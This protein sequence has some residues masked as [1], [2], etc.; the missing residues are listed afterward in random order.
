M[1]STYIPI[2]IFVAVATGFALFTL[3]FSSLIHSEKYNKV[4]LEPYECGID[5]VTEAHDRFTVR[6][7]IVAM[8]F[9]QIFDDPKIPI[10]LKG[11]IGR[12]QLPF[13]AMAPLLVWVTEK[14][15]TVVVWVARRWAASRSISRSSPGVRPRATLS[16]ST[17][18]CMTEA[19][20]AGSTTPGPGPTRSPRVT[21]GSAGG[22]AARGAGGGTSRGTAVGSGASAASAGRRRRSRPPPRRACATWPSRPAMR[23]IRREM[24]MIFQDPSS[25]LNPCFTVAYQLIETLRLHEGGSAKALR[26]RALEAAPAGFAGW[27]LPVDPFLQ[28]A[29]RTVFMP[30]F[31]LLGERA[32]FTG[33]GRNGSSASRCKGQN[34]PSASSAHTS[35]PASMRR[36]TRCDPRNPAAPVTRIFINRVVLS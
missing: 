10:A 35:A 1:P 24:T 28:V 33:N 8:L 16:T 4:N 20:S 15:A 5:P 23:P 31:A 13:V 14:S 27:W 12:L 32:A 9:D 25:S 22:G 30:V 26:G 6:Y 17:A 36:G 3:V 29:D 18:N 7:Y 21:S 34:G 19:S 2:A 11:L